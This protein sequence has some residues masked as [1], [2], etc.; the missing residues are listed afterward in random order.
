M[1]DDFEDTGD[2]DDLICDEDLVPDPLTRWE[3]TYAP[4]GFVGEW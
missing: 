1:E 4:L 3:R 2:Q